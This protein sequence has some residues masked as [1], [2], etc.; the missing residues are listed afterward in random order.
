MALLKSLL[1]QLAMPS[2]RW[3][4][5]WGCWSVQSDNAVKTGKNL[6]EPVKLQEI[7]VFKH[8]LVQ[9]RRCLICEY[10]QLDTVVI[11]MYKRT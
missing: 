4:H 1:Q 6:E 9:Q 2:C 7:T 11:D 10:V 3:G 8:A 5:K